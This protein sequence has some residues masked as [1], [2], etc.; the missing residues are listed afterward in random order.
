MKNLIPLN[1][2]KRIALIKQVRC[3]VEKIKRRPRNEVE[4]FFGNTPDMFYG[5]S[6]FASGSNRYKKLIL[7]FLL[8]SSLTQAYT[9]N[10]NHFADNGNFTISNDFKTVGQGNLPPDNI[11]S[12]VGCTSNVIVNGF[13]I[14]CSGKSW[15]FRASRFSC[16]IGGGGQWKA[17]DGST[18]AYICGL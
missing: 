2:L 12:V 5:D 10:W 14:T 15:Q 11:Q 3:F 16:A 13:T 18:G 7:C 4:P 17:P 6:C 8:V 1:L 9:I